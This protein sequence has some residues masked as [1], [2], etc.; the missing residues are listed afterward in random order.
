MS[1]KFVQMKPLGSKLTPP[2][3]VID[4]SYMHIQLVK[5]LKE[6][7]CDNPKPLLIVIVYETGYLP[8]LG[9]I[10]GCLC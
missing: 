3:G 2:K 4:F 1:T 8:G 5:T 9:D 6:S 10:K 7:S